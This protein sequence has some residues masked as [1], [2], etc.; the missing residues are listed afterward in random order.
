MSDEPVEVSVPTSPELPADHDLIRTEKGFS[1]AMTLDLTDDQIQACM[2]IVKGVRNKRIGRWLS[3][4]NDPQNFTLDEALKEVDAYED[5]LKYE[6][7]DK[8]GVLVTVNAVPLLEGLPLQIEWLGVLPGGSQACDGAW[9]GL[10]WAARRLRSSSRSKLTPT[11]LMRS[12]LRGRRER[13]LFFRAQI[14]FL[15]MSVRLWR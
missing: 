10:P 1:G 14:G 15:L 9:R 4:F 5:E 13:K 6:L 7:A 3:K 12:N 2:R 8:V 11:S